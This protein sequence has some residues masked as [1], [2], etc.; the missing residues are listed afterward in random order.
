MRVSFDNRQHTVSEALDFV[1]IGL[2]SG[3]PAA[4]RVLPAP[5][6]HGIRF[7]SRSGA[8][9]PLLASWRNVVATRLSTTL[10][11]RCGTR[12]AMVEHL[13]AALYAGGIDNARVEVPS[14]ELPV[15][16]GSARPW[17]ERLASIPRRRLAASRRVLVVERP[18]GVRDGESFVI[19]APSPKRR[20]SA[21][22]EFA[23]GPIGR[24]A[25]STCL[26]DD[27]FACEVA[28]AR[29]FGFAEDLDRLNRA[30]LAL[31]GSPRNAVVVRGG[32]VLNPEGL[33]F[34][35]EFVR[36]KLLDLVG[37]MAL[38]GMP[39]IG[40]VFGFRPG[41]SLNTALVRTLLTE[42]GAVS[43]RRVGDRPYEHAQDLMAGLMASPEL[44]SRVVRWH[45]PANRPKASGALD[46][47]RE[48]TP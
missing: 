37:D 15:L 27:D 38:A 48:E 31:G 12:V 10:G 1:G 42:P 41:H 25:S 46:S 18:V 44:T 24:Q 33:R 6:G 17:T 39:I 47:R 16:D 8:A 7:V 13:L 43:V 19:A 4:A 21:V 11:D 14:G 23:R 22:I 3:R 9:L 20:F 32:A 2:H 28:P 26:D 40:H 5:A 36:H 45:G 34:E 30:G 29:T 35:D